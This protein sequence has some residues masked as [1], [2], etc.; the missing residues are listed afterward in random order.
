MSMEYLREILE[1]EEHAEKIRHDAIAESKRI[2]STAMEE[3]TAIV[4][5]ARVKAETSYE[6]AIASANKE[7]S[8]DYEKTIE[9]AT[10]ECDML[11]DM[12]NNN[13]EKAVDIIVAKMVS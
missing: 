10:W 2:V 12:A 1:Q 7:A 8:S 3:A 9:R 6:E 11:S 4:E 5:A 13:L